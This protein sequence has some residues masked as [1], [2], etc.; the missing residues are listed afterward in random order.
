MAQDVANHLRVDAGI[1][2]PSRVTVAKHMCTKYKCV[3]SGLASIETDALTDGTA[4][5]WRVGYCRVQENSP[6]LDVRWTFCLKVDSQRLGHWRA[7]GGRS[8]PRMRGEATQLAKSQRN[9]L[10]V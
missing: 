6:R 4:G 1:D 10:V 2:L 9:R 7:R 3:D 8:A 5:E